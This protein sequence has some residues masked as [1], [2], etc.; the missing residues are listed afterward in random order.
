MGAT[1]CVQK[2]AA[3]DPGVT[4]LL[5]K[6]EPVPAN[7]PIVLQH[8]GTFQ[9]LSCDPKHVDS[10]DFGREFEVCCHNNL[11][12]AKIEAL[13]SEFAGRSTAQTNVRL[14]QH[15]NYWM[16]ATST[17]ERA[18]RETRNLPP[19]L[20]DDALLATVRK[21]IMERT[22]GSFRGLR[23]A[24][25]IMDD[26]RDLKLDREDLKWGL[27]DIGI[28]LHDDQF[29]SLMGMF[30]R[31]KDGLISLTEFLTTI[32]GEMNNRRL[33]FVKTAFGLLDKDGSGQVTKEDLA[34]CYD[35]SKNPQVASGEMSED[36]AAM[37]FLSNFE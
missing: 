25:Q 6:E 35:F 14:E 12:T 2:L 4:R 34:G 17:D 31:N 37:L 8:R 16:L 28:S 22:K 10:T 3:S 30:D 33:S 9:T 29:D 5:S 32:R 26:G 13:A 19:K 7:A 15:Q 21:M 11:G 23:K 24:F 36:D 20:T 27:Y 1:W 18:A